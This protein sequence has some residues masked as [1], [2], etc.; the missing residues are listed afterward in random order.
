[1]VIVPKFTPEILISA[2]RRA[3][4]VPNRDGT[5]ALF[6]QSTHTVGQ[7]TTLKEVRVMKVESGES[8][9]LVADVRVHGAVWL[10]DGSTSSVVWLKKGDDGATLVEMVTDAATKPSASAVVKLGEIAAPVDSLKVKALKDGSIAFL[11]VGLAD[12]DGE[13]YN[14]EKHRT[15]SSIRIYDEYDVR[16]WDTYTKPQKHAIFY[17]TLAKSDEGTWKLRTPLQNALK[18][19]HLDAPINIYEPDDPLAHFDICEGG[20]VFVAN[21]TRFKDYRHSRTSDIYYLPLESFNEGSATGPRKIAVAGDD[22]PGYCSHPRISPDGTMIAFLRAPFGRQ[23]KVS[24]YVHQ[25]GNSTAATDV[26]ATVTGKAWSLIPSGLEFSVDGHFPLHRRRGLRPTGLDLQPNA[27]PK[28]LLRDGSVKAYYPLAKDSDGIEKVFVSS[29][30]IVEPSIYQII[31][32]DPVAGAGAEPWTVSKAS[33]LENLGL[34]RKQVSEIYFEGGAGDYCVQAW[35]V[36]PR[37]FD[38]EKKYPLS[39]VVH[40]GPQSAWLD[41]WSNRWNLALWAEQGYIVVAPNITGSTGFGLDY[42]EAVHDNW[43]GGPYD[44]LV[45]CLEFVKDM[46]GIDMDNA[47]AVGASYGGYMMNW[48]QGHELGRRPSSATTALTTSPPPASRPTT[49]TRTPNGGGPPLVWKN[50]DG[51][52]RYNPARPDLLAHWTTPMLVVHSDGDYRV[53]VTDGLAAFH[54]LRALGTPARFVSFP[55]ENHWVLKPENSLQWHRVVFEWINRWSGVAEK[56]AAA[57]TT[58]TQLEGWTACFCR[59]WGAGVAYAQN[60]GPQRRRMVHGC[61]CGRHS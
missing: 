7:A 53:P 21:P 30:N 57:A 24:I 52:E 49:S 35:V 18:G 61:C 4:A 11:V 12:G 20:I 55:D 25:L 3:P 16:I 31:E 32:A 34:S 46:P 1:M 13:L 23:L 2:P 45:N 39:L 22:G 28:T 43:G 42:M 51:L 54:T 10:P 58:A 17:T 38:P 41:D 8:Q 56:T 48:I 19:S 33:H 27:S 50:H 29:A 14:P 36:K 15:L 5:L 60:V 47:V 44:D 59:G 26:F 37:D 9:Q 40:G 6:T